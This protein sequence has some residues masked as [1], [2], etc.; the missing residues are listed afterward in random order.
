MSE[1]VCIAATEDIPA[2]QI[3]AVQWQTHDLLVYYTGGTY[4]VYRDQCTHEE[5]PLSDGYLVKDA[6]VCRLHGAK[7]D[8]VSGRCL[9]APA[10]QNLH[11]YGVAVREGQLWI[12][13]AQ[14]AHT[15]KPPAMTIR[16]QH[17]KQS[18]ASTV[19]NQ[20]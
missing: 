4:Y 16:S 19:G 9:R 11:A 1:W 13:L 3:T 10:G 15:E 17:A 8:L 2:Q 12:N 7:F 20:P 14:P 18:L 5:V 6:I